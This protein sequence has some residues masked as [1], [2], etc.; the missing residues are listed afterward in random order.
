MKKSTFAIMLLA[1][2]AM[3]AACTQE[4]LSDEIPAGQVPLQVS[5]DI[6]TRAYDNVLENNDAIG[7]T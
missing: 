2:G 6:L 7:I 5:S 4:K 3:L 1:S